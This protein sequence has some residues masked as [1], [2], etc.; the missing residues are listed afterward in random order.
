MT[1]LNFDLNV[2]SPQNNWIDM[3]Q[4]HLFLGDCLDMMKQIPDNSVDFIPS[5]IPYG[6][7]FMGK[8]WDI[9]IPEPESPKTP[10]NA[11]DLNFLV[12]H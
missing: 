4:S 7:K 10:A 8:E 9:D 12:Q 1:E 3:K 6:L 2:E 11:G 5:D